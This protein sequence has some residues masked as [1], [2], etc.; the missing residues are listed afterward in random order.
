M[1]TSSSTL[2][3]L[4]VAAPLGQQNPRLETWSRPEPHPSPQPWGKGDSAGYSLQSPG[5][6]NGPQLAAH[7][8]RAWAS[9]AGGRGNVV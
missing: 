6:G 9:S 2:A 5:K 3:V 4:G 8:A 7:Q 1:A